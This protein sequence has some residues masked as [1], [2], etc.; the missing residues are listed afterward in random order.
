MSSSTLSPAPGR[1]MLRLAT[2]GSVDDGKSTLLGRLL[3]DLG[4]LSTDTIEAVQRA[5]DRRGHRAINLALVTDGL[6]AE[7][8]AGITIDVAYRFFATDTRSF[9][10]A[11]TPGHVQYTRNMV[12]GASTADVAVVLVDA[13]AGLLDQ[14]QRHLAIAAL[15]GVRTVIVAVNKCDLIGWDEEVFRT[16]AKDAATF[17]AGLPW[18][19]EVI[20]VPISALLGDNVVEPSPNLDWF[21]GPALLPLLESI[22]ATL[23][24]TGAAR[25]AVQWVIA[26]DAAAGREARLVAGQLE[27]GTLSVG[28]DVVLLPSGRTSTVAAIDL[29]GEPIGMAL[30]GQAIAV[31][32]ADDLDASRGELVAALDGAVPVV[33]DEVDIDVCWMGDRPVRA[34]DRFTVK[35]TTRN[36]RAVVSEVVGRLDITTGMVDDGADTLALN[37][38]GRLR[39][40]LSA[41]L[42]VEPYHHGTSTGR[43]IVIDEA[44]NTT[45]GA[46]M[47]RV[48]P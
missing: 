37:D 12:T 43:L 33:T 18:P 39:L 47:I 3:H 24:P 30:P 17:A 11:D 8:E 46:A 31:E 45:V 48:T 35:H 1:T 23:P 41:P 13:R 29:F 42:A 19:I 27:G 28:Q 15:L 16:V 26:P 7:R 6:R 25:L 2:A 44:T 38:L 32:L 10:L 20:A 5:S 36:V 14:S 34:G 4:M 22:D 9:I 40:R 21:E